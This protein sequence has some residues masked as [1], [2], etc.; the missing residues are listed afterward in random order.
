[1]TVDY[2][3]VDGLIYR[4]AHNDEPAVLL[5]ERAKGALVCPQTNVAH[6]DDPQLRPLVLETMRNN[7]LIF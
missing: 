1:M 4:N 5:Y 3:F 7:N 6:L 2:S